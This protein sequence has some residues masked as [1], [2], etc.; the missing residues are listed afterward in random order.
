MNILNTARSVRAFA[1]AAAALLTTGT[2]AAVGTPALADSTHETRSIA[3]SFADLDLGSEAGNQELYRRVKQA[4]RSACGQPDGRD[5]RAQ[6]DW[7]D[8][9]TQA[10]D[11][12][13]NDIG[14]VRLAAIHR[15]TRAG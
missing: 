6:F 12:V 9:Q 7:R 4:A 8:C 11:R 15:E 1:A 10:I 13:V 2:L 5:L 3:V 14:S